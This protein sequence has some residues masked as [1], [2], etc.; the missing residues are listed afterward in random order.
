MP[1]TQPQTMSHEEAANVVRQFPTSR[2]RRLGWLT[3]RQVGL[4][5]EQDRKETLHPWCEWASSGGS[6]KPSNLS[7]EDLTSKDWIVDAGPEQIEAAKAVREAVDQKAIDDRKELTEGS[8]KPATNPGRPGQTGTK[9][10]L[11]TDGD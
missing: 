10:K 8:N 7:R 11:G 2:M 5:N 9:A 6:V 1:E 4:G 3:G